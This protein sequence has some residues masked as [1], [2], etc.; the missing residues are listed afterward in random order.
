LNYTDDALLARPGGWHGHVRL[1]IVTQTGLLDS[2]EKRS[3]VGSYIQI[4]GRAEEPG[5]LGMDR[6]HGDGIPA[7]VKVG[8]IVCAKH[9]RETTAWWSAFKAVVESNGGRIVEHE[10]CGGGG[11]H[12]QGQECHC[13]H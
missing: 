10:V 13:G 11:D 2:R 5:R 3:P 6:S 1:T 4:E 7:D 9:D 8:H 12:G